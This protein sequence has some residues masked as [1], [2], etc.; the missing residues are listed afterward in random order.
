MLFD[1]VSVTTDKKRGRPGSPSTDGPP[2]PSSKKRSRTEDVALNRQHTSLVSEDLSSPSSMG[3]TP[4]SIELD[5]QFSSLSY[6][7]QE[8][9]HVGP[10]NAITLTKPSDPLQAFTFDC[11]FCDSTTICVCR[12]IA[13]QA[14]VEQAIVIPNAD[15][16]VFTRTTQ[17]HQSPPTSAKERNASILDDLPAY[18]PPVPLR[19]RAR[20]A[21]ANSVFPVHIPTQ[22]LPTCSGDPSNCMACAD[23]TFGQAFCSAI[24]SSVTVC[25]CSAEVISRCCGGAS[26]CSD[27]PS[28]KATAPPI[29]NEKPSELMP[30][31]DAWQKIKAH[32][33]AKFADL[34]LLAKVVASQSKCSGPQLVFSPAPRAHEHD[35]TLES[36]SAKDDVTTSRIHRSPPLQLVPQEVL[37]E[38]GRRRMRQVN[39][40]GV[41]EA[42]RL[43][44]V[45]FT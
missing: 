12:E 8:E 37:L 45:N 15:G 18:Q 13:A 16:S 29:A 2:F 40:A 21:A 26:N 36:P 5:G 27:C 9:L 24:G 38:C 43:L 30:T 32:P 17:N 14:V 34:A 42:L 10:Y 3:S 25:D 11:G 20:A 22:E 19:R 41:N 4:D 23:D 28:S 1:G 39:S 35:S 7:S 31:N 44:D 6:E 33:N